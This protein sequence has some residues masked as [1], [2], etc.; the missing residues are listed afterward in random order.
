MKYIV[1]TNVPIL[2]YLNPVNL[3]ADSFYSLYYY[4]THTQYFKDLALLCVFTAGFSI[5]TYFVIRRQK[6]ASL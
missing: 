4:N 3:I 2:G 6:Y 1:S 5:I